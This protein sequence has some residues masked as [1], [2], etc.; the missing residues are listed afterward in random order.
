MRRGRSFIKRIHRDRSED[1]K[2]YSHRLLERRTALGLGYVMRERRPWQF[3]AGALG[4][5]RARLRFGAADRGDAAFA[6]CDPLRRFMQIADR[7][8]T[9][10]RTVI[11]MLRLDAETAGEL[12]LGIAVAPA[13]ET[14]DVERLDVP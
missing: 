1:A 10:D 4:L 5:G 6:A 14:D 3:D 12:N 11:G 9:A 8:F 2:F 7:A 13:Q